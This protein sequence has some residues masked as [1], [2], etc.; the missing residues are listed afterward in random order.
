MPRKAPSPRR[1]WNPPGLSGSDALTQDERAALSEITRELKPPESRS[2]GLAD[3]L[4]HVAITYHLMRQQ[5]AGADGG[6]PRAPQAPTP[7][8]QRRTLEK[9]RED[10]SRAWE[11]ILSLDAASR[12]VLDLAY[13][14]ALFDGTDRRKP[15]YPLAELGQLE[16]DQRALDRMVD[17]A[18][19]ALHLLPSPGGRRPLHS[20]RWVVRKLATIHAGIT[21]DPFSVGGARDDV[22]ELN[23]PAYWVARVVKIIDPTV[24]DANLWT[25]FRQDFNTLQI[26]PR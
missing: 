18:A 23:A 19:V 3:E 17:R 24:T 12:K 25:A 20:L 22:E 14:S 13:R 10:L 8:E 1:G 4:A 11:N 5:D 16:D 9:L 6:G 15:R 21:G 7:A 26:P 2:P